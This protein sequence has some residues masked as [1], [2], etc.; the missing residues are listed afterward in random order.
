M[1][2]GADVNGRGLWGRSPL[3]LASAAGHVG[4]AR[5]LV[6]AEADARVADMRGRTPLHEVLRKFMPAAFRYIDRLNT[7]WTCI[8]GLGPASGRRPGATGTWAAPRHLQSFSPGVDPPPLENFLYRVSTS[9]P[10]RC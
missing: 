6:E 5:L 4:V 8:W 3:H 9:L 7:N 10:G 2:S 1:H